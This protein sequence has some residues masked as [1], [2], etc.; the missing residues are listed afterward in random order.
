MIDNIVPQFGVSATPQGG[1]PDEDER[2]LLKGLPK[3]W[4]FDFKRSKC[5]LKMTQLSLG[6][7]DS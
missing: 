2:T 1:V 5:S 7:N 6:R 4:M 3:N